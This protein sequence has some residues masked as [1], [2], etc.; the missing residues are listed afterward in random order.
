MP[1]PTSNF[2]PT[3]NKDSRTPIYKQ[4]ERYFVE[5][6]RTRQLLPHASVQGAVE[7]AEQLGISHLTV[8]QSYRRLAEQGLIYSIRGKG[9]FV[10]AQKSQ[11]MLAVAVSAEF[12]RSATSSGVYAAI[13]QTL[14][15]LA[16]EAGQPLKLLVCT[17]PYCQQVR[18]E[19]DDHDLAQLDDIEL[20]GL[21]ASGMLL[22]K[23][24]I[25]RITRRGAH[26][27]AVPNPVDGLEHY[28]NVDEQSMISLPVQYLRSRGIEHPGV[29]YLDLEDHPNR[30]RQLMSVLAEHGY[31]L[32]PS[33]VVGVS[34]TSVAAGQLAADHLLRTHPK[35]DGLICYDDLLAQGVCASCYRHR[36]N[37]PDDLLIVAHANK[38]ITP[39]FLTPV[40][41]TSIDIGRM[42]RMAFEKMR[43]LIND[44]D[45]SHIP[46]TV[47]PTLIP[48]QTPAAYH[49]QEV[50]LNLV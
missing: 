32:D 29:I 11:K 24:V 47:E 14:H 50:E 38:N 30:K 48:E 25:A 15:R 6:I 7:L 40:A 2:T 4:I 19:L 31:D 37:V 26:I 1:K 23:D 44:E 42:V 28:V 43:C 34:H 12:F 27:V 49:G 46:S 36:V 45:C 10:A 33:Q 18:G 9:T 16:T 21:F 22:P 13:A 8:R 20:T 17:T 5:Q 41:R 39:P 35:I 3:L